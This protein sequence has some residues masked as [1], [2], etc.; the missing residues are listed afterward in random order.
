VLVVAHGKEFRG[1]EKGNPLDSAGISFPNN[2]GKPTPFEAL[3][4]AGIYY[5]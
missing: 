3:W 4:R 2:N 5:G 1:K